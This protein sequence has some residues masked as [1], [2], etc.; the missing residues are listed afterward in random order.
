[1]SK[2]AVLLYSPRAHRAG[3]RLEE[4]LA[5]VVPQQATEIVHTPEDLAHSLARPNNGLEVAVIMAASRKELGELQPLSQMLEELRIILVLP[6]SQPQTISQA[7]RLRPR[8]L[9]LMGSDFQDVAAV[10]IKLRERSPGFL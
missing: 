10:L 8:Y 6:D 4:V 7:H 2:R 3:S 9:T 5:T 1:M